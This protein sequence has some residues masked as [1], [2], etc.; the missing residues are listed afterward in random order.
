MSGKRFFIGL[1]AIVISL[2]LGGI[3]TSLTRDPRWIEIPLW[4]YGATLALLVVWGLYRLYQ[5]KGPGVVIFG[6]MGVGS[7]VACL[8]L[9]YLGGMFTRWGSTVNVASSLG[10]YQGSWWEY[11][12]TPGF[13]YLGFLAAAFVTIW[14][15]GASR[16]LPT[17]ILAGASFAGALYLGQVEVFWKAAAGGAISV[18][19]GTALD[20]GLVKK[21]SASSGLTAVAFGAIAHSIIY[22]VVGAL[23]AQITLSVG[24]FNPSAGQTVIAGFLAGAGVTSMVRNYIFLRGV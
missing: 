21:P 15:T 18:V 4:L 14:V 17:L 16:W 22:L 7:I 23:L 11:I 5:T 20:L 9:S 2:A 13:I 3:M 10:G 12:G 24:F 6:G 1:S 19:I 8:L